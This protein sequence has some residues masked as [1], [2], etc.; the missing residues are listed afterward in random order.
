MKGIPNIR[1]EVS[2]MRQSQLSTSPAVARQV[3]RGRTSI[4]DMAAARERLSTQR[5]I[6]MSRPAGYYH[7]DT[8]K[9]YRPP[10][11]YEPGGAELA[12][13]I[14]RSDNGYMLRWFNQNY[15][16]LGPGLWTN[17]QLEEAA[18]RYFAEVRPNTVYG[19]TPSPF[20]E[21]WTA[22]ATTE[23]K[24]ALKATSTSKAKTKA[25]TTAKLK[26]LRPG[27]A[28]GNRSRKLLSRRHHK[29][30]RKVQYT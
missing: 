18:R 8:G 29:G 11:Q 2:A 25:K 3:E 13:K 15:G 24:S 16:T 7:K 5:G 20:D 4:A 27:V 23:T 6:H 1:Q 26:P 12:N 14:I 28:Y 19:G 21:Y 10:K 9:P 17:A 30:W 22:S